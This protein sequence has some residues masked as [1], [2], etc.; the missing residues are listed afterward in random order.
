[1]YNYVVFTTIVP[2]R[3]SDAIPVGGLTF[4]CARL[5]ARQNP[6]KALLADARV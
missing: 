3:V 1:M 5:S 6:F 2:L 4:I